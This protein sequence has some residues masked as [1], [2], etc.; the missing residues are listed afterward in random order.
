MNNEKLVKPRRV[1]WHPQDVKV[2]ID[3]V[4]NMKTKSGLKMK[5]LLSKPT[6]KNI[7]LPEDEND[8]ETKVKSFIV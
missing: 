8:T 4:T 7:I 6:S 1:M 3:I 2:L 5:D